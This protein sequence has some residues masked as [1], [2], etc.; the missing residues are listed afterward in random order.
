LDANGL[1]S[2]ALPAGIQLARRCSADEKGHEMDR[3]AHLSQRRG[4]PGNLGAGAGG[5]GNSVDDRCGH[6]AD[7]DEEEAGGK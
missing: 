3:F 4:A 6:E 5:N 2:L 1:A 7:Y